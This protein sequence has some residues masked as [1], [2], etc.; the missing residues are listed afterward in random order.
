MG[1]SL[2]RGSALYFNQVHCQAEREAKCDAF[3]YGGRPSTTRTA[4][5]NER[6]PH[7]NPAPGVLL[8]ARFEKAARG[9]FFTINQEEVQDEAGSENG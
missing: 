5:A 7:F 2:S 6:R 1:Q 8:S 9:N 3:A 4:V